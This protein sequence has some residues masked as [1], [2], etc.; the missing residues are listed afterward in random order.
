MPTERHPMGRTCQFQM[1]AL[2]LL[3]P[4]AIPYL[5]ART[6]WL[7]KKGLIK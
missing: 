6:V 3:A 1:F 2:T 7:R 5:V 4:V